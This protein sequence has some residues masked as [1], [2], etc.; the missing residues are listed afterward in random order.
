MR[1]SDWSSDVCSSDLLYTLLDAIRS[2]DFF[3]LPG[4][5]GLA[6]GLIFTVIAVPNRHLPQSLHFT[7]PDRLL[8]SLG[9]RREREQS[10]PADPESDANW[11]AWVRRRVYAADIAITAFRH[12]SEWPPSDPAALRELLAFRPRRTPLGQGSRRERGG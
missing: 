11:Q 2:I 4:L 9:Y 1:I 3:D 5:L 12:V 8:R 10:V 6:A 7:F